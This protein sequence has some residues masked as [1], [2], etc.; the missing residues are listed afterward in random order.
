VSGLFRVLA[1][2]FSGDGLYVFSGSEDM[3][4]RVWKADAAAQLGTVCSACFETAAAHR[5][6]A[7]AQRKEE[8]CLRRGAGRAL[9]A[10]PRSETH[11]QVRHRPPLCSCRVLTPLDRQ[12]HVP[13]AVHKAALLRRTME[14]SQ[15]RKRENVRKHSAPDATPP[16]PARKERLVAELH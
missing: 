12:R 7:V 8:G 10:R 2:R 9:R 14:D 3:N 1:V 6:A 5:G 16:V 15:R 13:K 11:L 4:V